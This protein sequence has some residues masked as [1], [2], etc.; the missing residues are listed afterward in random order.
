MP[1]PPHPPTI[2]LLSPVHPDHPPTHLY[3]PCRY[4]MLWLP[5]CQFCVRWRCLGGPPAPPCPASSLPGT[6]SGRCFATMQAHFTSTT[7]P[8]T[9][10][11]R[12]VEN[13]WLGWVAGWTA[14]WEHGRRAELDQL[15][16][17]AACRTLL[18]NSCSLA[19]YPL[20]QF[21]WPI[22]AVM[23]PTLQG[24]IASPGVA[25]RTCQWRRRLAGW[26]CLTPAGHP[27]VPSR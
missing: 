22:V 4:L 8:A 24:C 23:L 9:R 7:L 15:R 1:T 3:N 14:G 2:P 20:Q 5:P 27:S 25:A 21:H 12:C 11:G 13:A 26:L 18:K 6:P 10:A 17:S 16:S 19:A